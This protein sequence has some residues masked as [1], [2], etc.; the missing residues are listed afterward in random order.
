[1]AELSL[2]SDSPLAGY[3]QIVEETLLQEITTL[4]IVSMAVPKGGL[5]ALNSQLLKLLSV[6]FPQAGEC[7]RADD[8]PIGEHNTKITLL[9]LQA[10]QCL[11]SIDSASLPDH[12]A[13]AHLKTELADTAYLTE[14]SDSYAVLDIKGDLVHPAL[15]RV[16]MLDLS[17][18]GA[19]TAART[20]MEHLSVVIELPTPRHARLYS[21]RSTAGSFLH[22]MQTSLNN[23]CSPCRDQAS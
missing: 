10:E 11:L 6:G 16:C 12:H 4:Q 1:M 15:E 18:F 5:S 14:Q 23:V 13:Y 9:G 17:L 7:L 19:T 20:M 22:A 8:I 21:P 3:S 2:T